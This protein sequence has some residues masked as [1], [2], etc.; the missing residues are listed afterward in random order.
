MSKAYTDLLQEMQGKLEETRT[1]V[2]NI[3]NDILIADNGQ[4]TLY[5]ENVFAQHVIE[6][7][8]DVAVLT[9]PSEE[10]EKEHFLEHAFV[11]KVGRHDVDIWGSALFHCAGNDD[12]YELHLF[13][14]DYK[15]RDGLKEMTTDDY[16][17]MYRKLFRFYVKAKTGELLQKMSPYHPAYPVAR[18][19]K[20]MSEQGKIVSIRSWILSNR[21][22][23][24]QQKN[25]RVTYEG[26][27]C[28]TSIVDLKYLSDLCGGT[29]EINQD[30]SGIGGI[31]GIL[32]PAQGEQDY[33]CILSSIPGDILSQLYSN[34]GTA[35]VAANVRAYL[36]ERVKINAGI[37]DT[38]Q[39]CP[40]RFLAYNNGL[41]ITAKEADFHDSRL[42]SLEGIQII[43]GGQ[44]TASIY[45]AWLR[46][47]NSK[48]SER[49]TAVEKKLCALRV[50]V[51]VIIGDR[52]MTDEERSA[53]WKKISAT[54][55]A[56]N[57][58]K[59]SDLSAND[60]F[61]IEFARVV[62]D[63]RTPENDYW[64]YE[65]ARGLYNA[66]LNRIKGNRV[67][68]NNFKTLHKKE[69]L[70]TKND[71]ATAYMA[72]NGYAKVCAEGA[73]RTFMEFCKLV[74]ED[75]FFGYDSDK[76]FEITRE[77]AQIAL[78][79][80]ILFTKL[81]KA[82]SRKNYDPIKNPKVAVVYTL[83]LLGNKY[84]K[85]MKWDRIWSKQAPSELLLEK[86]ITM[87]HD[88]DTIIR[89]NLGNYMINMF[90]RQTQCLEI[91]KRE[92][93]FEGRGFESVYELS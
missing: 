13:H 46:A 9:I 50:P 69:K 25:G 67:A 18:K 27:E 92:F 15:K 68:V 12:L 54:A 81:K 80:W 40:A 86:M 7:L 60:P 90:G 17:R 65:R 41:V 49:L 76:P 21:V 42:Y 89:R 47:R 84:G 6:Q 48:R 32:I 20:M 44:T 71:L 8:A 28:T 39:E 5:P 57:S 51:K 14:S 19:I 75:P 2:D 66:E 78:C 52:N 53:F 33:D 23:G 29:V 59:R 26:I 10:Q 93:S 22:F 62:N 30:F 4:E 1:K 24:G 3:V 58:V 73:E 43:N 63:M 34:H 31:K 79:H 83:T 82:V 70:L 91:L 56:Q 37:L 61:Q 11:G 35:I 72:W 77:K 85:A 87:A 55:N 38:I 45:N 64:F 16:G 36:G 88:V 74:Q